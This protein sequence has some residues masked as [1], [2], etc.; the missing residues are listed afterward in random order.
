MGSY[1]RVAID[2]EVEKALEAHQADGKH[3]PEIIQ[4]T[5]NDAWCG[6]FL[7]HFHEYDDGHLVQSVIDFVCKYRP[8]ANPRIGDPWKFGS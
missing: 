3:G 7:F 4:R 5:I 1:F 8:G 2:P 6:T